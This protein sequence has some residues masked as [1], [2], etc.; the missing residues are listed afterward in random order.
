MTVALKLVWNNN[1]INNENK[2]MND[3][4]YGII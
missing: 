3:N 1:K 2:I 4:L